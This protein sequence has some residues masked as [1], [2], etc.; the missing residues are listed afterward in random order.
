M[1]HIFEVQGIACDKCERKVRDA[2]GKMANAKLIFLDK[3]SGKL[4]LESNEY[5]LKNELMQVLPE[6]VTLV[7]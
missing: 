4:I 2:V 5:A 7:S 6:K 1:Q 3:H